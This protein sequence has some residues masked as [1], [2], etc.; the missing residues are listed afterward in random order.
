M[1]KKA[2]ITVLVLILVGALLFGL[3]YFLWTPENFASLGN[4]AMQS[5]RYDRAIRC[6]EKAADMEPE[7]ADYVLRLADACIAGGSYTKAERSLVTYIRKAPSTELYC[8]LSAVYIAQDKLLDAQKMLDSITDTAIRAEID[9]IRPAAPAIT[10]GNGE[11]DSYLELTMS[12]EGGKIYYSLDEQY[13]ST[14]GSA[15]G[16]PI[17]LPAGQ[18]HVTAIL[19]SDSNSLVSP[20]VEADYLIVGVVEPVK[21]A[22]AELE[23]YM[24]D[25][26]Y[27]ARTEQVMTNQLW[28]VT[29]LT[30][31]ENVTDL[32][33]LRYFTGLTSL[34]IHGSSAEDY[35]F[36]ASTTELETLDLSDCLLSSEAL[37]YVGGL[38]KLTSLNLSGCGLSNIQA[39]GDL[40]GLTVL[41]LSE[42]SISDISALSGCKQLKNLNLYSNAVSTLTALGSASELTSLNI[43]ENSV[44]SIAP[45]AGCAKLETLIADDNQIGD[46][47]ALSAAAKLTTFTASKNAIADVSALA[48]CTG[49]TRLELADNQLTSIEVLASLV[50]LAYLDISRNQIE[51]LP[52]IAETAHLQQIYAAN[53]AIS[54]ISMLKGLPELTYVGV[55]YNAELEEIEEL[56]SCPVLVQ[57]DAFGTKVKQVTALTQLGVIVNYNPVEE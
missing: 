44:N 18:T 15:Y 10:P 14:S 1:M 39:L 8:K 51:A 24:R 6:Y 34:T 42:N 25:E 31:P 46:V 36:L 22:S 45:L 38:T 9:A 16:E 43:A 29:E 17:A 54:D 7:N 41:D 56:A 32:S 23:A 48:G 40:E 55:D 52:V 3:Y 50:N 27:V 47:S 30:I 35:S 26:L 13:P 37:D 12:G 2:L 49:L 28:T 11:Y 33:D 5:E 19:V 53:N 4:R 57:V 21:F 20:L